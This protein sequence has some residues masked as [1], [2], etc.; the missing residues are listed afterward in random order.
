MNEILMGATAALSLVVGLFFLR[1]WRNTHDRFFLFLSA[2]FV[3]QGMDRLLQHDMWAWSEETSEQYTL[4]ILA[5]MLILL[6]V[7]DKNKNRSNQT[8]KP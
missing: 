3:L 1:F 5:Y 8:K 2:S 7:L 6:A 4:R